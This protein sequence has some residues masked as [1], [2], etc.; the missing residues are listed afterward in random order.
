MGDERSGGGPD[1]LARCHKVDR[2]SK[3]Q[4]TE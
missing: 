1:L 4:N 3:E 2:E